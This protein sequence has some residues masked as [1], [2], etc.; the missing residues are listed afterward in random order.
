MVVLPRLPLLESDLAMRQVARQDHQRARTA[1]EASFCTIEPESSLF[2]RVFVASSVG[3]QL[4]SL[5][6]SSREYVSLMKDFQKGPH[7]QKH[8]N[9]K[10]QTLDPKPHA[11]AAEDSYLD[12]AT[13]PQVNM[14]LQ[15]LEA[16]EA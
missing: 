8:R 1:E 13:A 11:V 15:E 3:S 10:P 9:P 5:V 16:P 12:V 14:A 4:R 7:L 2:C 6:G